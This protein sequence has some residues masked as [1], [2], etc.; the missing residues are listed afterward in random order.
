MR[1][2]E[3][4][5]AV[6]LPEAWHPRALPAAAALDL[7]SARTAASSWMLQWAHAWPALFAG[8]ALL[9]W[10]GSLGS[11]DLDGITGY[12][13]ISVLPIQ[14]HL[15]LLLL[16]VSFAVAVHRP[17]TPTAVLLLHVAAFI[18]IVHGTPALTYGTVRYSWNWKH[19]GIV[20][21]IQR[22]H[23]VD[24]YI[25]VLYVYHNWPGFFAF[26]ALFTEAAGF[27]SALDFESWAPVFFNL[28][29]L[30]GLL[31]LTSAWTT[32]RRLLWLTAWFFF[33]TNWVGQDYFA[34]QALVFFL[35]LVILGLC[36]RWFGVGIPRWG[37]FM[38][39]WPSLGR[40][41]HALDALVTRA[42]PATVPTGTRHS[43]STAMM[44][45]VLLLYAVI[46]MTHQL[47]PFM[48]LLSVGALVVARCCRAWS[49]PIAMG[50]G[51]VTWV[52]WM[53][54]GFVS[55]QPAWVLLSVGQPG[56]NFENNLIDLSRASPGQQFVAVVD[57]ALTAGMGLLALAGIYQ[58]LRHGRWDLPG[59]L[60]MVAPL[61]IIAG[62]SY[63]GE[64]LFRIYLFALPMLAFFAA[65]LIYPAPW[66]GRSRLM[67]IVTVVLSVAM[68][69]GFYFAYYGKEIMYRFT[70]DEV[71]ASKWLYTTAP[72]GSMLLDVLPNYPWSFTNYEQ[73]AY[74]SLTQ[75]PMKERPAMRLDPF[76]YLIREM[77]D[78]KY[79]NTYF[80]LNRGQKAELNNSGEIER[81]AV[82]RMEQQLLS[83][84][85][86]RVVYRNPDAI[87]F[88]LANAPGFP[89]PSD[90]ALSETAP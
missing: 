75:I 67:P 58:R 49:L 59:M 87:V 40:A 39:R 84:D 53:A 79:A 55:R 88:V 23:S 3:G 19:A 57:R 46:V 43:T 16:T 25:D 20:D 71:A 63:G 90:T 80:I 78:P 69:A 30:S 15:A 61:P 62:N 76:P 17:T 52:I 51:V 73:F 41:V 29:W 48:T 72:P 85:L 9:L 45:I 65:A 12:G 34:P 24:P 11:I 81:G 1:Q 32:D 64:V 77:S 4:P 89:P 6:E 26:G 28:L 38:D 7:A 18:L 44:A 68:V 66:G 36:L 27:Q 33:L 86:V 54:D 50:L 22:H 10:Y 56:S 14:F 60:L 35:H 42:A 37:R 70:P 31:V 13:L 21:Y 47:T 82:D 2:Q 83:S 8:A 5:I 74:W